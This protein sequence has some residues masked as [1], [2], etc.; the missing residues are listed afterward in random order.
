MRAQRFEA[1]A[2]IPMITPRYPTNG[3]DF[4]Q[5]VWIHYQL[6]ST[7]RNPFNNDNTRKMLVEKVAEGIVIE[8][9]LIEKEKEAQWIVQQLIN[10]KNETVEQV[11]ACCAHFY[12]MGSFLY[13]LSWIILEKTLFRNR[14]I[15]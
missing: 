2:L 10:I 7:D 6:F 11:Y 15:K 1:T 4:I 13:I 5:S 14:P 12:S 3:R 8:E 9:K